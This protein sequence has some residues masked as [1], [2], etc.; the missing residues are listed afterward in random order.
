MVNKWREV[1]VQ[2]MILAAGFGT[3]LLPHTRIKPKP[4][5][6]V[7][8]VPLLHLTIQRLQSCGFD[9]IV[10]N[11]HHLKE[12][13]ADSVAALPGVV[14]QEE[15][16]ILGTGGG[17][18][19]ALELFRE[20][21]LLI[22]NGDIY[23]TVDYRWLYESHQRSGHVATL[24]MHDFARFNTVNVVDDRIAFFGS[25]QGGTKLA[26]T[27]L[28]VI[29]PKIL[30]L[31]EDN[32]ES[33]VI[34]LYRRLLKDNQ[35]LGVERVD[36]CYWTDMGTPE[37]YLDL[38]AGLLQGTIPRWEEL[39]VEIGEFRVHPQAEII[40]KSELR[41]WCCVGRAKG[42]DV[43]L[44]RV[45]IWDGV[46]LQTGAEISDMLVSRSPVE[47]DSDSSGQR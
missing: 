20:E 24:A 17:L 31:V 21:P 47:N 28:H 43:R 23:H 16:K 37:D 44:S 38:H 13:I 1:Q 4:L 2:A 45:V 14:V 11:C 39:A 26:F 7:L 33:C 10:V 36:H 25:E 5:F 9:H 30:E 32:V 19:R 42:E 46:Q 18:R 41:D 8:N 12:Q 15:E 40:G 29:D 3:R 34:D 22:T 6:P 27:G 35:V